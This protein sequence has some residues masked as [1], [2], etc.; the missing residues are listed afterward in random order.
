VTL[1]GITYVL[2]LFD[3][4]CTLCALRIGVKELNP[5]IQNTPFM[6]F[7]KIVIV[8]VLLWW[9]QKRPE[10]VARLGLWCLAAV[11]IILSIYHVYEWGNII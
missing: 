2:N 9:L 3:L 5:F 8:G 1:G 4:F 10:R 7:Y 6:V 11:N